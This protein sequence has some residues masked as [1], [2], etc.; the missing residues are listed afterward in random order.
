MSKE[1]LAQIAPQRDPKPH[2]GMAKDLLASDLLALKTGQL[3][4]DFEEKEKE[5]LRIGEALDIRG[6]EIDALH[7]AHGEVERDKAAHLALRNLEG[8]WLTVFD[9][10]FPIDVLKAH[11]LTVSKYLMPMKDNTRQKY[12]AKQG[13]L[14]SSIYGY[15]NGYY[16]G[17][18]G[19]RGGYP[20]GPRGSLGGP[21]QSEE[22]IRWEAP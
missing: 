4:L 22:G 8:Y 17:Y 21:A 11:D 15:S 9:G 13:Q 2:N 12:D 6:P 20:R 18:G 5:L 1:I 3:S 10:A 14:A 16:G 19:Y 7:E